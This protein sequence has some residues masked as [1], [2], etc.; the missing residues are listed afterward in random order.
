M[1]GRRVF[2]WA[3]FPNQDERFKM[4]RVEVFKKSENR[5]FA[6]YNESWKQSLI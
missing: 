5:A 1:M 6:H 4:G 2:N 3:A